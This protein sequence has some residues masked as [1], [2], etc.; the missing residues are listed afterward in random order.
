MRRAYLFIDPIVSFCRS[1]LNFIG[2]RGYRN[3]LSS[4]FEQ[5]PGSDPAL[6]VLLP[7]PVVAGLVSINS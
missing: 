3:F 6:N 2:A 5:L 7:L 4:R 1:G